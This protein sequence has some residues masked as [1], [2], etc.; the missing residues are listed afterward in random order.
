MCG[1]YRSAALK[2]RWQYRSRIIHRSDMKTWSG[3]SPLI[4]SESIWLVTAMM[5]LEHCGGA[6]VSPFATFLACS[7]SSSASTATNNNLGNS[8]AVRRSSRETTQAK[9]KRTEMVDEDE[10]ER[11][12]YYMELEYIDSSDAR[13]VEFDLFVSSSHAFRDSGQPTPFSHID[14]APDGTSLACVHS[15]VSNRLTAPLL[16][17]FSLAP[18]AHLS[19]HLWL[20]TSARYCPGLLY[21]R[22]SGSHPNHLSSLLSVAAGDRS[23]S[24]WSPFVA[25]MNGGKPLT[26]LSGLAN[27]VINDQSFGFHLP[28]YSFDVSSIKPLCGESPFLAIACADGT[29]AVAVFEHDESGVLTSADAALSALC[30]LYGVSETEVEDIANSTANQVAQYHA[31]KSTSQLSKQIAPSKG[32]KKMVKKGDSQTALSLLTLDKD[33]K[34]TANDLFI[35]C[36]L[37]ETTI[38]RLT[39]FANAFK[40]ANVSSSAYFVHSPTIPNVF[41]DVLSPRLFSDP[42]GTSSLALHA[43]SNEGDVSSSQAQRVLEFQVETRVHKGPFRRR[44]APVVESKLNVVPNGSSPRR[45]YSHS[46]STSSQQ[47]VVAPGVDAA[48]MQAAEDQ[49]QSMTLDFKSMFGDSSQMLKVLGDQILGGEKAPVEQ[50][51]G[52]RTRIGLSKPD[53][54]AI[55]SAKTNSSS[56]HAPEGEAVPCAPVPA[57]SAVLLTWLSAEQERQVREIGQGDDLYDVHDILGADQRTATISLGATGGRSSG[58]LLSTPGHL[59]SPLRS[60]NQAA[61]DAIAASFSSTELSSLMKSVVKEVTMSVIDSAKADLVSELVKMFKQQTQQSSESAASPSPFGATALA[62]SRRSSFGGVTRLSG[63]GAGATDFG[64]TN[65]VLPVPSVFP[66]HSIIIPEVDATIAMSHVPGHLESFSAVANSPTTTILLDPAD[67]SI[68]GP[69]SYLTNINQADADI[70]GQVASSIKRFRDGS[71]E[72]SLTLTSPVSVMVGVSA[73]AFPLG[74]VGL[75][76]GTLLVLNLATGNPLSNEII[77]GSGPVSHLFV[78]TESQKPLRKEPSLPLVQ[79]LALSCSGELKLWTLTLVSKE[80]CKFSTLHSSSVAPLL[81]SLH[82]TTAAFIAVESIKLERTGKSINDGCDISAVVISSGFTRQSEHLSSPPSALEQP[83]PSLST[84]TPI[85]STVIRRV[86]VY[87]EEAQSW[88]RRDDGRTS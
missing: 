11:Q 30:K 44:I 51:D 74:V 23:V 73:G 63:F 45:A 36:L 49:A 61:S 60:S 27:G 46:S 65:P 6:L 17:R 47:T 4:R 28:Q 70:E 2:Q 79:V 26:V 13:P 35:Y 77:F 32:N 88:S 81:S 19:G 87:D 43:N 86:F 76:N 1:K 62:A 10:A 21:R 78:L 38:G 59:R 37:R 5:R 58:N 71:V 29:L 22:A 69:A 33:Q 85:L 84:S 20:T 3:Q 42:S 14:W 55:G 50:S 80:E 15:F 39:V 34:V 16:S 53:H 67:I 72:W 7:L 31:L 68:A 24:V 66:M 64:T 25:E 82:A 18:V 9:R 57:S 12:Q 56:S 8:A 48:P 52:T 54:D 83:A 41:R 40:N 75:H